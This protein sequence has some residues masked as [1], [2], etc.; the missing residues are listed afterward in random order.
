MP[1]RAWPGPVR[2]GTFEPPIPSRGAKFGLARARRVTTVLSPFADALST[3]RR[4][5]CVTASPCSIRRT[6]SEGRRSASSIAS[7]ATSGAVPE[8]SPSTMPTRS[9]HIRCSPFTEPIRTACR[10]RSFP[11]AASQ[12][13]DCSCMRRTAGRSMPRWTGNSI[14][15]I[16]A[17]SA[18]S[19][20]TTACR[21]DGRLGLPF[22]GAGASGC[23]SWVD[24]CVLRRAHLFLWVGNPT[25]AWHGA[26]V[27]GLSRHG[28]P[29][30]I[31]E[32]LTS[33]ERHHCT[34][35]ACVGRPLPPRAR[36]R[37]G[38]H[39]HRLPRP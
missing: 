1:F 28:P 29:A 16:T 12:P 17:R 19:M 21:A 25:P 33:F 9:A 3:S 23:G 27:P 13:R 35:R 14:A 34:S 26:D 18:V 22:G 8:S 37:T 6:P 31:D 36:A 4:F 39:G 10:H 30:D 11:M 15:A 24:L 38:R 20:S 2:S 7:S 5:R 32:C